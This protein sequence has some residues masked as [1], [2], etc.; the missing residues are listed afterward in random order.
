[1]P[2]NCKNCNA[3]LSGLY[4]PSCGQH[5][6]G[7]KR[8]NWSFV[9]N[10]FVNNILNFER[11]FLGTYWALLI[12][13]G[14]V[15][16]EYL[17]G[18]RKKY[19]SPPRYFAIILV[20]VSLLYWVNPPNWESSIRQANESLTF[21][22]EQ[23]RE[24]VGY[25]NYQLIFFMPIIAALIRAIFYPALSYLFWPRQRLNFVEHLAAMFYFQATWLSLLLLFYLLIYTPFPDLL[26]NKY[27]FQVG[28]LIVWVYMYWVSMRL[29]KAY[30]FWH[31]LW[32]AF[33]FVVTI[34]AIW[35]LITILFA[36]WG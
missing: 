29:F 15:V 31:R 16:R 22:P 11:G 23:V 8:L 17:G 7:N 4:C 28:I 14:V 18:K 24:E 6:D 34:S 1:M 33:A 25:W 5:T 9:A 12:R 13:P 30:P 27:F 3:P 10:D 36:Y 20:L 26:H 2:A 19:L 35:F 32:R 21:I